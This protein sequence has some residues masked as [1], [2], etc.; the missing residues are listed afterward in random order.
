MPN[1]SPGFMPSPLRRCLVALLLALVALGGALGPFSAVPTSAATTV[2]VAVGT[3]AYVSQARPT[4]NYGAS[5][6]LLVDGDSGKAYE[7]Y[8]RFAVSGLPGPVQR[9]TLR[10]YA[11]NGSTN[12][13]AVYATS[14]AWTAAELTWDNRPAR[15]GDASDDK[16]AISANTWVEF[17]VTPLIAGDGTH[18]FVLIPASSDGVDFYS[19]TGSQP[20]QLVLTVGR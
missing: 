18:S 1:R 6:T 15:A 8:L 12:G 14:N 10:L 16:G 7:S 2:T 3:D 19:R 5:R 17:D 11:T 4:T 13:P 9:A 20:P